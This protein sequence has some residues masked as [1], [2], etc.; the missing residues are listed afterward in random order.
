MLLGLPELPPLPERPPVL[1]PEHKNLLDIW[2]ENGC[3][4][5]RGALQEA[6]YSAASIAIWNR[7][8]VQKEIKRRRELMTVRAEITEARILAEYEKVAFS[9]LG[10]LLEM[11]E[12]GS[13]WIDVSSMT[14]D[15]KDA[16]A[17]YHVETY[18]EL[19]D[20]EHPG[21]TVKKSRIKFHDKLSA[22]RDISRILG[23]FKDKL[24][25]SVGLTLNDKV[26]AARERIVAQKTI[27][28]DGEMIDGS[29]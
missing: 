25:V 28:Q 11:N 15:Q 22:L 6:G 4:S 8:E 16:L 21:H 18:Q 27:T 20:D 13:G 14:Q 12:D 19:G 1:L 29:S 10:D 17:E 23:L 26:Q 24:E 9:S 5:K 3:R 2:F 7:P